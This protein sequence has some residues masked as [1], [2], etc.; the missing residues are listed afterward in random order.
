MVSEELIGEL[1]QIIYEDYKKKLSKQNT[2]KM[3]QNL[4]GFY[5]LLL[6]VESKN[7]VERET[8]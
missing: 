6:E 7:H 2:T 1:K 4:V 3:A 5:E 8:E